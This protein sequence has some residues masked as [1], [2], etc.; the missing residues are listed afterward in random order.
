[1]PR[2]EA[3][4]GGPPRF[5]AAAGAGLSG[6]PSESVRS[7]DLRA[8]DRKEKRDAIFAELAGQNS[9]ERAAATQKPFASHAV[10]TCDDLANMRKD[11]RCEII[12]PA[13]LE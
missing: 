12:G 5:E 9:G 2:Y 13:E 6:A 4:A 10:D 11:T 1:M 3:A 7:S 8:R